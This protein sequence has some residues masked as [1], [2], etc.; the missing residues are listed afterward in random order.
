M[1]CLQTLFIDA[2]KL[3]GTFS[4]ASRSPSEIPT[5][6]QC[7]GEQNSA[8]LGPDEPS[9]EVLVAIFSALLESAHI[10]VWHQ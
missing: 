3:P 8:H 4:T 7:A 10:S 2:K 9:T 1:P 6:S 5:Q